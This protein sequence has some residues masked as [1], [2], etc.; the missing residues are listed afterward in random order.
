MTVFWFAFAAFLLLLAVYFWGMEVLFISSL[1]FELWAL[2][3]GIGLGIA[4]WVLLGVMM[5]RNTPDWRVFLAVMAPL[6]PAAVITAWRIWCKQEIV[7]P[8]LVGIRPPVVVAAWAARGGLSGAAGLA[9]LIPS[10]ALMAGSAWYLNDW[11]D[12]RGRIRISDMINVAGSLGAVKDA[13]KR[14]GAAA[15]SQKEQELAA[16]VASTRVVLALQHVK[17]VRL[18]ILP[19]L[20]AIC[21]S[22]AL[23]RVS[24]RWG[25]FALAALPL[26]VIPP[27]IYWWRARTLRS[28]RALF[29]GPPGALIYEGVA[30]APLLFGIGQIIWISVMA[31]AE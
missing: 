11:K 15:E 8:L 5:R 22:G 2:V 10:I 28:M 20:G 6:I 9:L 13:M 14:A 29:L 3:M 12:P 4:G 23:W 19:M 25:W 24:P 30:F 26:A 18:P 16:M 21:I 1:S 7:A 17:A 31:F 27:L